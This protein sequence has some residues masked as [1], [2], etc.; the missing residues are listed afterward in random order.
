MAPPRIGK[1]IKLRLP[2][3]VLAALDQRAEAEGI[4]RAELLRRIAAEYLEETT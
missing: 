3:D 2:A 4:T 1:L